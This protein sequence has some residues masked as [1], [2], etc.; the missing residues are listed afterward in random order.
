MFVWQSLPSNG[1]IR[2]NIYLSEISGRR[3]NR[4][5]IFWIEM[6]KARKLAGSSRNLISRYSIYK[7]NS[8]ALVRKRTISIERLPLVGEVSA[9]FCG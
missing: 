1:S 5:P 8:V 6:S 7:L 9:N 3:H 4:I 2:Y